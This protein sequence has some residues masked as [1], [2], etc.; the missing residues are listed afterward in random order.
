MD[1]TLRERLVSD[2]LARSPD[3]SNSR[4][5]ARELATM[6]G[7]SERK[8]RAALVARDIYISQPR[9]A[10]VATPEQ[11]QAI[12]E[13][14]RSAPAGKEPTD[15]DLTRDFNLTYDA[16]WEAKRD[17][18]SE[19]YSVEESNRLSAIDQELAAFWGSPSYDKC[20]EIAAR[21]G[22]QP[23]FVLQRSKMGR[24]SRSGKP[25]QS[26]MDQFSHLPSGHR[27]LLGVGNV[28]GNGIQMVIIGF[29]VLL[30]IG[31]VVSC[32]K[33]VF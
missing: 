20:R 19:K 27:T 14:L 22:V 29:F 11:K 23:S 32:A 7:L 12:L 28:M 10:K 33:A 24:A 25:R 31:G 8:V 1:E 2:Y 17:W 18:V 4:E 6:H 5:I 30:I 15:F 21:H 3:H 9:R 13:R 26:S 16:V